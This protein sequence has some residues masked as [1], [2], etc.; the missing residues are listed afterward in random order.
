MSDEVIDFLLGAAGA[1]AK[2]PAV[3]TIVRGR[4]L[5]HE[6]RQS[7]DMDGNP[8]TW[9]DGNPV[10]EVIVTLQTEDRDAS[11][12]DDDGVRR[13]FVRGQMLKAVRDSLVKASWRSSL[14]GGELAVQYTGDG[15]PARNGFSAPK[16]YRAQFTPP[17]P[18]DEFDEGGPAT[19]ELGGDVG[20]LT[21]YSGE[22]F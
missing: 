18:V 22:P 4:V 15:I 14:I 1:P 2:F 3:G 9:D 12:E 17:A 10:W 11:I 21:Q 8:K 19:T 13:L 7:R 5:S 16:Q 20:D 6:K